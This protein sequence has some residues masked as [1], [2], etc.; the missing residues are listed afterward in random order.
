MADILIK[1]LVKRFGK[2]EAVSDV[3][4][5]IA[6]GEFLVLLGPSG[7]GKSTILRVVAGLEDADSGE[8]VIGDRLVN[9]IDPVKRN[10]AMVFQNYALYP[11][12]TVYKNIAFPLR[13]RRSRK[14]EI[15]AA[16]Q[17]AGRHP[18]AR[19][20]PATACPAQLSGGQRQRVALARA[21][22]R[23][24]QAFLMDEP[25]SNLDAQLR[26][27]TRL[28]LIQLHQRLGITT[29]YVTHDQVEAM[30]MGDRIA[31]HERGRAAAD[32]D[33]AG[34]LP[35]ACERLRRDLPRLAADE[36]DRR[37]ARVGRRRGWRFRGQDID[38]PLSTDVLSPP[39]LEHEI[40]ARGDVQFGLRPE[41]IRLAAPGRGRR[42]PRVGAVPRAGR[43]RSLPDGRGRRHHGS[44]A[45]R[46]RL[47]RCSRAT[48]FRSTSTR[49][50]CTS[51]AP[52]ATTSA[53]TRP[54][55]AVPG[56]ARPDRSSAM[57]DR[58]GSGRGR[59]G[60]DRASCRPAPRPD[61]VPHREPGE[62]GGALPGG[63]PPLHRL[64]QRLPLGA[65]IR[66]RGLGR[67]PLGDVRRASA[68]RRP[69]ARL[70]RRPLARLQR[71]RRRRPGRRP[72]RLVAGSVR[73][74][75]RRRPPLRS[76]RDRHEGRPRRRDVGDQ[77]AL[78]QGLG[79]R[80]DIV[81]HVVSDEEVVGNGT[82]EIVERHR[83][84]T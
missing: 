77:V 37:H 22:V 10:V 29:M 72:E 25:L 60:L 32:R 6:D 46:P 38:V 68:D 78:E 47:D 33:A 73:R 40:E 58:S 54:S 55:V 43:L 75:R 76:R 61:R 9:F 7:C 5:R 62:G 81:F 39:E 42:R 53:A 17:R 31:V 15:D 69:P 23:E 83:P 64:R 12:M 14:S 27:Q 3:S 70:G 26:L 8:I 24:P 4:L 59:R 56:R 82:R 36:P 21:I 74:R 80:G 66:D 19:G 13:S 16:V 51:S 52:T 71:P 11:H 18:G 48:T 65:R 2:V 79:P 34:R 44:G 45:H 1:H 28:E 41:H 49:R 57:G 30:T 67:R 35:A 84:A 50:A 63:G 20:A